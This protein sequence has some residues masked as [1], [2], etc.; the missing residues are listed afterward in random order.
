MAR[1]GGAEPRQDSAP[2]PQEANRPVPA[3]EVQPRYRECHRAIL[4][5]RV[6]AQ[7][8]RSALLAEPAAAL[9]RVEQLVRGLATEAWFA[10]VP[11][12]AASGRAVAQLEGP[13]V[14]ARL[15]FAEAGSEASAKL[16]PEA[17]PSVAH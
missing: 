12:Q 6:T 10:R 17:K 16:R 15:V 5:F 4:I 2:Q 7:V 3:Q 14:S 1:L 11:R 9:R 13:L 8:A